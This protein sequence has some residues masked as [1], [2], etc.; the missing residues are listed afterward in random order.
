MSRLSIFF[1]RLRT[2]F[3]KQ[4]LEDELAAEIQSHL[5]MQIEDHVRQGMSP[6]EARFLALRKFGGVEQVK[7]TYR[8][9][10]S[11]PQLETLFRDLRYGFRMLRRS[12]GVTAVAILSLGLGIGA[13]TALFSV[14]DA[15]LLKTLPVEDA[16][17]L[18][19]FEWQAGRPFRLSGMSGTS[20]VDAPPGFRGLSLFRNDVFE[21][22][23]HAQTAATESPLTDLFAFAPLS[24][25]T[26]NVSDQAEVIN[27][28]AVSG[29]YYAALRVHASL[30]RVITVDDDHSGAAPVVMLSHKFWQERFGASADVIG[31]QL[32]LNQQSFT[33]VGITP[34]AFN[35][36]LQV[37]YYPAVTIPLA[38]EPLLRGERST[39]GSATKPGVW[40][41][42]L[43]GRLKPGATSEQARESLNAV[44]QA[45]ALEAMPPPR[46]S[47][48]PAQLAPK[49]YPRL[50]TQSGSH[51]ML[52]KR[53]SYAPTI[54]GLFIVVALV[55]LIACANL[56]NLLLARATLRA[57]EIGVRLAIGAGRRRLIRQLLTESLLLSTLGGLVGVILAFW[58]KSVL[59][60]LTNSDTG[61]LPSRVEFTLNWR[62]LMF[63]LIVSIVTG[64]LFGLIPAWRATRLDLSTALKQSS[65]TT[66]GVSRLSKGLLVIQVTVS[67]L[68]LVGAG[69]FIRTLYNLQHVELGFNHENLLV[70]R[71]QPE[72]AGYKD[73]E[74]L[75]FYQQLFDRLDHLSGVR[76]A[77]FARIELLADDNSENS[78]L[79]P[80]ETA[81]TAEHD[82]MRQLVRENYFAAM[83]IPFLRGREFTTQDDQHAPAVA[84]VN[85]TFQRKFF[86]N[87]DVLG[88]RVIFTDEKREV[89]IVGVVADARYRLQ[90]EEMQPLLYTPWRQEASEIGEMH[91]ALRTMGDPAALAY[92]VRDVVHQLDGNLPVTE[93]GTQSGRAQLALGQERLYARLFSFFGALALGLA[94]IG[95]FGV[96]AY[97]VS[98]RTKEIGVRMAFGAR[99]STVLRMVIWQGMKLVLLGLGVSALIGYAI[100]RLLE[101]DYFG[102]GTWQRQLNQQLYGVTVSDRL[103]WIVIAFLLMLVALIAC[104]LPARRAAKVDP[105]VALRYE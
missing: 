56:A 97:S 24:E 55:L 32:K 71:L 34:E 101:K 103:T 29:N 28:Q 88:K 89:E 99:V 3:R 12:P 42:N 33:I 70:F 102:P 73:E 10:R 14:V 87:E 63:T 95:L 80:G 74:L 1:S 53:K 66:G 4:K 98:Q 75:R 38:M 85:Q 69:L 96:L 79:F 47:T 16:E 26:A 62:V 31:K 44:F 58:G 30:G 21:K 43:M 45:A 15:V 6:E 68:L 92:Q 8:D 81:E 100:V 82:T 91:F 17:R 48:D 36:T 5:E 51:G 105:M 7:E 25:V 84:I 61:L 64:V 77:T 37:G 94:A 27:G 59:A 23:R 72:K 54:Y 39:L 46:K 78:F 104:W 50:I 65:R 22:M 9:G 11:L 57:P 86:P 93:V 76:A 41:L 2:L 13:N 83:E 90:R 40:W 18:V 52:D 35:G 49:D 19:L 20:N 60:A 67:A